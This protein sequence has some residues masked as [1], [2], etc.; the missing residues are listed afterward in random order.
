MAAN[1]GS[2]YFI[3]LFEETAARTKIASF[4]FLQLDRLAYSV[5]EVAIQLY[6]H[7]GRADF[8]RFAMLGD[9]NYILEASLL[10]T[11]IHLVVKLV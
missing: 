7:E 3:S 6:S 4:I 5:N 9:G 10:S 2:F 11:L 1:V 8:I